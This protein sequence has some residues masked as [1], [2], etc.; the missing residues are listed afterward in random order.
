MSATGGAPVVPGPTAPGAGAADTGVG[1]PDTGVG[2]SAPGAGAPAPRRRP[3]VSP[4]LVILLIAL[5]GSI[6][7]AAYTVTVR[8]TSQIGLLAAGGAALGIVFMALAVYLLRSTW[9]AGLADRGGRAVLYAI[10]GGLAAI[11]GFGCL[12]GSVIVFL[13]SRPPG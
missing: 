10:G 9:R 1:A 12:A 2:A 4:G 8:D 13:L 11:V 3:R 7:F 5:F 6:A